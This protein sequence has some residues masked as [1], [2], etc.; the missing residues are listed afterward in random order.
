ML[1]ENL[2]DTVELA[3]VADPSTLEPTET[4]SAESAHGTFRGPSS[5]RSTPSPTTL[6]A[7]AKPEVRG[8]D[9]HLVA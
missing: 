2:A 7:I 9:G 6:V 1:S 5:S 8:L 4:T 3:Q